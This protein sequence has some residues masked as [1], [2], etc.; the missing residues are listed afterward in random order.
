[1]KKRTKHS[2]PDQPANALHL[3][4]VLADWWTRPDDARIRLWSTPEYQEQAALLWRENLSGLG[5][6]VE[7]LMSALALEHRELAAEYERLFVGPAAI[8]CPPYEAVWRVDGPKHEQDTVI[9]VS[10]LR[11]KQL[12][13]ELG[14]RLAPGQVELADHIAVEL[15][16]LA[17]AASIGDVERADRLIGHLVGWLPAFCESVRANSQVEF[18]CDLAQITMSF[19]TTTGGGKL[20]WIPGA[21]IHA[22]GSIA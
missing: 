16:A 6:A 12:Y 19:F 7:T 11:V 22:M 15:E 3:A 21:E 14:V 10:T 20:S 9:G 4:R 5:K 13:I 1:M 18:Y 8:P 17:Y 2:S